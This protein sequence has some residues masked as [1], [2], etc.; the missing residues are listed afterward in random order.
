MVDVLAG[1]GVIFM[2]IVVYAIGALYR[3]LKEQRDL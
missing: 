2:C 3:K 1:A